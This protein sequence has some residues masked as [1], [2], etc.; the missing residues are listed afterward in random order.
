[1]KKVIAILA[2]TAVA[3]SMAFAQGNVAFAV[4]ATTKVKAYNYDSV[5]TFI[6]SSY[7][8]TTA[9]TMNYGL[10]YGSSAVSSS[11]TMVSTLAVNSTT[12]AGFMM[13]ANGTTASSFA[14]PGTD[15]TTAVYL[16]VKGWS[17]SFGTDW[18]TAK[19]TLG[20]GN[21]YGE[22]AVISVTPTVAPAS[23]AV[24]WGTG[25]LGT[26]V[27]NSY[28]VIPEPSTF[29]LAGLG[30]AAMLIFRRRNQRVTRSETNRE[31]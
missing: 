15:G 25:K 20:A 31:R 13:L 14:V 4:G 7:V 12:G 9:G 23:P 1:M 16:Q 21:Y 30:A 11:L 29:A 22:T 6:S 8:P 5:G 19:T 27:V 10:F 3:G 26:L 17:A 24:I 2:L 28:T 18:A